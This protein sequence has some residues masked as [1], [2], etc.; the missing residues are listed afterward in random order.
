MNYFTAMVCML[1]LL[2]GS[3]CTWVEPTETGVDVRVAYMSQIDG[4]K[5]LGK[6]SVSVL[7]KVLFVSRSE[8]QVASELE[9]SGQNAAAEMAGD[10]IVAMSRVLDGTQMFRVY[11]CRP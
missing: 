4:C 5:Q 3:G 9:I 1:A 2:V 8:Q 11:R 6:V 10:T 7:D